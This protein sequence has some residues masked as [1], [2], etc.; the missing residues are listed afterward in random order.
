M[1][2]IKVIAL[3]WLFA[4]GAWNQIAAWREEPTNYARLSFGLLCFV[5]MNQVLS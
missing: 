1:Q 2:T 4:V 3:L 5:L